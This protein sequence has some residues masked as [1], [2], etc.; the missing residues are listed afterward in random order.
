MT[1]TRTYVRVNVGRN[2]RPPGRARAPAAAV[3]R[4]GVLRGK[5]R[6][7]CLPPQQASLRTAACD[8]KVRESLSSLFA[9]PGAA[10]AGVGTNARAVGCALAGR[11]IRGSPAPERRGWSCRKGGVRDISAAGGADALAA[12]TPGPEWPPPSVERSRAPVPGRHR[13]TVRSQ[14][15][16][17]TNAAFPLPQP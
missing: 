16:H 2:G 15:F 8:A 13:S 10:A 14:G 11:P 6:N 17:A 12:L 3:T 7:P 9:L 1:V 4:D 5:T